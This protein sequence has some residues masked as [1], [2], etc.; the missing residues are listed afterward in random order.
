MLSNTASQVFGLKIAQYGTSVERCTIEVCRI[1]LIWVV[2]ISLLGVR[3]S[4]PMGVAF[5]LVVAGTLIY[6]EIVV[7]NIWQLDQFTKQAILAKEG[8]SVVKVSV[9]KTHSSTAS[10]EAI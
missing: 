3:V 7:L 9:V 8:L 2:E 5:L 1:V 10:N 4:L 6:N